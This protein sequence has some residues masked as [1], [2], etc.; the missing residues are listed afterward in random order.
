MYK[1]GPQSKE[2]VKGLCVLY[3]CTHR[4]SGIITR[5]YIPPL[6]D[7]KTSPYFPHTLRILYRNTRFKE[8]NPQKYH[9]SSK[10]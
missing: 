8:K 5:R 2:K 6:N 7:F 10:E 4:E 3:M 1:Y 9:S